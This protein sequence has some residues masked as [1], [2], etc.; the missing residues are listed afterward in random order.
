[1]AHFCFYLNKSYVKN[2]GTTAIYL[3]TSI[4]SK[5]VKINT[6][7]TVI[8]T[9]W[10]NEKNAIKG[11]SKAVKDQ[12]L[13]LNNCASR[14]TNIFVKYRL[15]EKE[16]TA[17]LLLKEYENPTAEIDFY[18]FWEQ[19]MNLKKVDNAKDTSRAHKSM[20]KKMRDFKPTLSFSELDRA[21]FETYQRHL[22][23]I[24]NNTN[25][26]RKNLK[27]IKVYV[28]IALRHELLEKDPFEGMRIKTGETEIIY[29]EPEELAKII[30]NYKRN[31]F[32]PRLQK[33]VRYYLF[34]CFTGLRISDVKSIT[35][36]NIIGNML[37]FKPQKTRDIMKIVRVKLTTGALEL[38]HDTG[39]TKGIIFNTF[40]D[41]VSNRYLKD[42]ATACN[43]N[44]PIKYHS[45]RHTFATMY[46]RMTKNVVG[47]QKLL[48]HSDIK[49][50]MIYTH[51]IDT[52]IDADMDNF[53]KL[54]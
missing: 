50:T 27:T 20:L 30:D 6:G 38:I 39:N 9:N 42:V 18:A 47:L 19:E 40:A 3:L 37:V 7:V 31:L 1:M 14:L 5:Q 35:H 36:D 21:F 52:D 22:K 10:D 32:A 53:N 46:Y 12:N 15:R 16:L 51:I 49:L 11:N 23:Q 28:N 2:D 43:I 34:S 4:K 44:K 41:A 54:W 33:V 25:T 13:I 26:I 24:G 48:G 17:D 29:L 8:P 45:A